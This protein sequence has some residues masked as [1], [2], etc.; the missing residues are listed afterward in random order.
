MWTV[1]ELQKKQYHQPKHCPRKLLHRRLPS[2][3]VLW[4]FEN[5]ELAICTRPQIFGLQYTRKSVLTPR[6]GLS[7]T[8]RNYTD[9]VTHTIKVTGTCACNRSRPKIGPRVLSNIAQQTP[10]L[11][12]SKW[13]RS[14]DLRAGG[15]CRRSA[16]TLVCFSRGTLSCFVMEE[17]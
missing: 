12:A 15:F 17:L 4:I 16:L 2:L 9:C 5:N 13:T 14:S 3:T 7:L 11:C 6:L 1:Y 10:W 8:V